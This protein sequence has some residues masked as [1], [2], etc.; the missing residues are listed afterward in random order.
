MMIWIIDACSDIETQDE[1]LKT[2][3]KG[4]GS[5]SKPD[6]RYMDVTRHAVDDGWNSEEEKSNPETSVIIEKP[7]T[8]ISRNKSPDIPFEQSINP[9][10]GC[11]HGC[12]YCY[13]RPTHA[14]FDLSPGLDFE[15]KLF[16]K[17]DAANLLEKELAKQS[18]QCSPIAL[19]QIRILTNR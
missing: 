19:G 13:A 6:A 3:I 10:R 14:Y 4:R 2:T 8:I 16:A 18:Y 17:T 1:R 12:I 7:R 9:Y 15:T 5:A 11:E